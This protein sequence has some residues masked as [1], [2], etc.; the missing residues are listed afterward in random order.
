MRLSIRLLCVLACVSGLLGCEESSDAAG[1][2]GAAGDAGEMNDAGSMAGSDS[3]GNQSTAGSESDGSIADGSVS[4]GSAGDSTVPPGEDAGPLEDAGI[5]GGLTDADSCPSESTVTVFAGDDIAGAPGEPLSLSATIV[6][7]DAYSMLWEGDGL[8]FASV[9]QAETTVTAASAGVYTAVL[10][11]TTDCEVQTGSL[12]LTITE[13]VGPVVEAGAT[14]R[15]RPGQAVTLTATVANADSV[16]WSV[17]SGPGNVTFST[18]DQ[19]STSASFDAV[20]SYTLRITASAGTTQS[21]ESTVVVTVVAP[22]VGLNLLLVSGD[23]SPDSDVALLAY[24]RALGHVVTEVAANADVPTAIAGQDAVLISSTISS[25]SLSAAWASVE[26]P[27][28]SWE[29]YG[30]DTL[31]LTAGDP[32]EQQNASYLTTTAGENHPLLAGLSGTVRLSTN[33]HAFVSVPGDNALVLGQA[34]NGST[35][36]G[37]AY[38][39]YE[40][41]ATMPGGIALERRVALPLGYDLAADLEVS[42]TTASGLTADAKD[43]VEAALAWAVGSTWAQRTRVMPLGDSITRGDNTI[44][45]PSYRLPLYTSLDAAGCIFDMVGTLRAIKDNGGSDLPT[46]PF[47]WDHEGH[48]G[49]TTGQIL[50]NLSDYL[51]G[52]VPEI[53]LLHLGTN[54]LLQSVAIANSAAAT[55]DIIA[56][57][58]SANPTVTIL[59]AQIIPGTKAELS[60]VPDYNAQMAAIAAQQHQET[61]PVLLVDQYTGFD[62][63]VHLADDGIHPTTAGDQR[64]AERWYNSLTPFLSCDT[65]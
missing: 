61:S 27:L 50:M 37:A 31:G 6:S 11:V 24:L 42:S 21:A 26:L 19:A 9:D 63:S 64:I 65:L 47:D 54:D 30:Y 51:D 56:E 49:F 28:L 22:G 12:T 32:V 17:V 5:D 45:A 53:V 15:T 13:P 25:T 2:S 48:G 3:A 7:E 55:V 40:K 10:T 44:S 1:S 18:P 38:F 33:G 52:N 43:L 14:Q 8:T 23:D 58:R 35:S 34:S 57:L 62:V 46:E 60:G 20:G 36:Y 4:D 29:A 39:A 41:G 16:L 59:L